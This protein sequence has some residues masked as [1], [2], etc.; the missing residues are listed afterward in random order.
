MALAAA[1]ASAAKPPPESAVVDPPPLPPSPPDAP[2]PLGYPHKFQLAL[3]YGSGPLMDDPSLADADRLLLDALGKQAQFGP[4]KEPRPSIWDVVARARWSAWM[5]LGNRSKMEAMFMYVTTIEELAPDW[6]K[7]PELGLLANGTSQ[8]QPPASPPAAAAPSAAAPALPLPSSPESAAQH[9]PAAL[10]PTAAP[11]LQLVPNK[12]AIN[13]WSSLPSKGA[14]ARYR[15]GCAVVGARLFIYGGRS[16]SGRL[17]G[18]V[19]QLNLLTGA[20]SEAGIAGSPPELRWGHSMSAY[21]QWV[22]IFGGHRKREP[23]CANGCLNDTA[24]LD[25]AAMAWERA[26]VAPARCSHSN[27]GGVSPIPPLRSRAICRRLGETT[28][29]P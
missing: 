25:T 27:V 24:L 1:G 28:L 22:V 26:Q 2:P 17:A 10:S 9:P 4:C 18:G 12:I 11:P 6:W 29:L 16:N 3:Q 21:R 19:F 7:W 20:W 8:P 13:V 15:H 5:E 14:P 23:G